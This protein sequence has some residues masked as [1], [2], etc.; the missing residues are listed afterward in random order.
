M[1]GTYW[2]DRL[3][4]D[5][6]LILGRARDWTNFSA[7]LPRFRMNG[8]RQVSCYA[9]MLDAASGR[10]PADVAAERVRALWHAQREADDCCATAEREALQKAVLASYLEERGLKKGSHGEIVNERGRTVFEVGFARAIR[11]VLGD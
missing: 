7:E 9:L 2:E 10:V 3:R 5:W 1:S 11:K 4:N 8:D 6:L